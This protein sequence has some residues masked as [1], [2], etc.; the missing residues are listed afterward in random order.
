MGGGSDGYKSI[1]PLLKD[2]SQPNQCNASFVHCSP[3]SSVCGA[4]ARVIFAHLYVLAIIRK[5]VGHT[6][7]NAGKRDCLLV[8]PLLLLLGL[9]GATSMKVMDTVW[10]CEGKLNRSGVNG[11]SEALKL[12]AVGAWLIGPS[13]SHECGGEYEKDPYTHRQIAAYPRIHRI[14]LFS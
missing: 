9:L 6:R 3:Q 11:Y 4:S 2:P 1:S 13:R 10:P 12:R 8:T 14:D 5:K 7:V